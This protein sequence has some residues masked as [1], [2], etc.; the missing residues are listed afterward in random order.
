MYTL[1]NCE[2][3]WAEA[4]K[5]GTPAERM[6]RT[7]KWF[8]YYAYLAKS[9]ASVPFQLP[10]KAN[11]IVA[12]MLREEILTPGST[13]LDIGA[14]TGNF[15]LDFARHCRGVTA[16]EPCGDCLS[17]LENRAAAWGLANMQ[18]VRAMWEEYR[19]EAAFDVTFSAMCPAICSTE[20]LRRMEAMTKKTCCLVTVMRGSYDKHR[21]AMM[22]ELGIQPQ[23]GMTSEAIHYINA[24]YLMGRQVNVKCFTA[25][26]VTKVPA[27]RVLE[28]YPI[29]FSIFGV[30]EKE[31]VQFLRDYLERNAADGFLEDESLLKQAL[32][33][34]DVPK[35]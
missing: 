25:R 14:G 23:G 7:E 15:S 6:A 24:L 33:Y 17:V 3:L 20:E 34:W 22:R 13:V 19:P 31:S 28:Q 21:K 9:A 12:H 10:E 11:P 5:Q 26:H 4:G 27:Q 2:A 16:L 18:T 1:E 32:I 29:Y 8:P 30:P 35:R